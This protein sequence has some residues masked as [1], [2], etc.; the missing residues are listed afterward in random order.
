MKN[1]SLLSSRNLFTPGG[2]L[3]GLTMLVCTSAFAQNL[4]INGNFESSFPVSDPTTGWAIVFYRNSG[5][6]DF[7]IAGQSTEASA[8]SGG[9][10]AHLRANHPGHAAAYFK[11]VVTNLTDGARYTI[12]G[13]KMKSGDANHD[14]KQRVFMAVING[15]T[16]NLLFGNSTT[17]GPYSMVVTAGPSRQ[18]EIQLHYEKDIFGTAGGA[19]TAD[20]FKSSECW[21]HF[22]EFSLTLTP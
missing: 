21:A 14:S 13:V 18:I 15:G 5:A 8:G 9:R 11:Q 16:S 22:D 19:D 2:W 1:K 12:N 20:D 7:A 3:L 4:L 17:V 6:A 10:G